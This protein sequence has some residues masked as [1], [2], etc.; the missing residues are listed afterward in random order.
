MLRVLSIL[1]CFSLFPAGTAS[2]GVSPLE[3]AKLDGPE[4]TPLGAERSGNAAGTIPPWTG[5]ITA[6][7]PGYTPGNHHADP[8][9][10]DQVLFTITAA[11]MQQYDEKLSEGQKALLKQ[12][13]DSW[14]MNVYPSR[15]SASYPDF[16]YAALKANATSASVIPAGHGGVR[17]R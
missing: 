10:Q 14:R 15:R 7:I 4:L 9:P 11:N 13:P 3:A 8:Y 5:G 1:F 16:V 12:Y 2:G 6:P 17:D